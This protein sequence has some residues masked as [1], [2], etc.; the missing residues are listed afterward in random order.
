M[1][2]SIYVFIYLYSLFTYYFRHRNALRLFFSY[3][4][5]VAS[6]RHLNVPSS[7]APTALVSYFDNCL[8]WN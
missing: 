5:T 6:L 7:L 2:F 8:R 3:R 4:F 1:L